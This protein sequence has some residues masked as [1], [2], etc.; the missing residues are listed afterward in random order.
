MSITELAEVVR[1]LTGSHSEITYIP[2]DQAYDVGFEDIVRRSAD[3]S[4]LRELIGYAPTIDLPEIIMRIVNHER[5]HEV[6]S[7]GSAAYQQGRAG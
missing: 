7:D 1:G 6:L 5:Q 3:I 2:Y 4:K